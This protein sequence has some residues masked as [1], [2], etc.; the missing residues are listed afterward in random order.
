MTTSKARKGNSV[1]PFT[2]ITSILA[3]PVGASPTS[4]ALWP[5]FV[6]S[7]QDIH[8]AVSAAA[9]LKGTAGQFLGQARKD[10][11]QS[12]FLGLFTLGDVRDELVARLA[13]VDAM[14]KLVADDRA[15]VLMGDLTP[16]RNLAES[17]YAEATVNLTAAANFLGKDKATAFVTAFSVPNLPS[18]SGTS[19]TPRKSADGSSKVSTSVMRY[20]HMV[21]GQQKY[22]GETQ[23]GK[24][25]SLAW[26]ACHELAPEGKKN[27]S[28]G[29]LVTYATS[30]GVNVN[31]TDDWTLELPS[32]KVIGGTRQATA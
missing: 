2:P 27:A 26:Y 5:T 17:A 9:A 18:K 28:T 29:D 19:S 16:R 1:T 11:E 31:A 10:A 23:Q 3:A 12:S 32:G 25:S 20:W 24:V 8:V 15:K 21:D 13:D 22:L 7:V 30:K 14:I 6:Q 4:I